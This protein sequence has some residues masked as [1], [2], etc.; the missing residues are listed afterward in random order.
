MIV[1]NRSSTAYQAART[2]ADNHIGAVLVGDQPGLA[3]IIRDL[4]LAVLGGGLDATTTPLREVMS[5]EVITCEIGSDLNEV[6]R[7][8]REHGVRRIPLVEGGR[9]VGLITFDDLVVDGSINPRDVAGHCDR[10]A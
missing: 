2:M 8:M 3:G 9:P 10:T 4:A 7:L 1:L 6:V 5:E